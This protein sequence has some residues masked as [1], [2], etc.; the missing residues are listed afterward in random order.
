MLRK[1]PAVVEIASEVIDRA[2]EANPGDRPFL[3]AAISAYLAAMAYAE[4]ER[5]VSDILETRFQSNND[6]KISH[7]LSVTYGKGKGRIKKSDIADLAQQFGPDCKKSFNELA[8]SGVAE[9]YLNLLDCR[10]KLA[11]GEPKPET[12][13]GIRDGVKAAQKLLT[14]F[15]TAIK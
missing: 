5:Q 6:A 11:H 15:E 2:A 1:T 10:H 8:D 3:E 4:T 14:A 12:L 13:K 7:F 9:Q